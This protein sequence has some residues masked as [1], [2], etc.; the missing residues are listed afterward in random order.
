F[1]RE[2]EEKLFVVCLQLPA[3]GQKQLNEYAERIVDQE[4]QQQYRKLRRQELES[5]LRVAD[6]GAREISPLASA[7]IVPGVTREQTFDVNGPLHEEDRRS[8]P[9]YLN[10]ES[11]KSHDEWL[12]RRKAAAKKREEI[13]AQIKQLDQPSPLPSVTAT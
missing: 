9:V 7:P 12:V 6:E 1:F 13:Q 11:Q 8:D 10:S 3:L 2:Q 5:E 4:Y